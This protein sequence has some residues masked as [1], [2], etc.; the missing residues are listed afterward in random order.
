MN[1]HKIY[2]RKANKKN[3]RIFHNPIYNKFLNK[4][5]SKEIKIDFVQLRIKINIGG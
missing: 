3:S 4:L 5:M 1:N 2:L